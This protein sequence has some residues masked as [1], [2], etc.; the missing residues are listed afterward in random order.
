MFSF[1][2][3]GRKI[4]MLAKIMMWVGI[5]FSLLFGLGVALAGQVTIN[6]E[7]FGTGVGPASIILGIIIAFVG[8]VCSWLSN[9]VLYG[10]GTVVDN[11]KQIKDKI[12]SEEY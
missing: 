4:M 10:F 7:V 1:K 2:N 8:M 12:R 9:L 11:T 5:I 6:G 3:V